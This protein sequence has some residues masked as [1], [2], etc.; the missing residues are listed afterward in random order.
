[1]DKALEKVAEAL[2]LFEDERE[3]WEQELVEQVLEDEPDVPKLVALWEHRKTF[4]GII[5]AAKAIKGVFDKELAVIL[6]PGGRARLDDYLVSYKQDRKLEVTDPEGLADWL[7]DDLREAVNLN[8]VRR[9]SLRNIAER[10]GVD[11]NFALEVFCDEQL[12]DAKLATVPLDKAPKY[13][14][15]MEH[16]QTRGAVGE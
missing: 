9:T 8:Q 6:G 7:G 2:F 15:A 11:P 4:T 1:M 12:T 3:G 16:G 14:Q 10:R 5:D 13:A